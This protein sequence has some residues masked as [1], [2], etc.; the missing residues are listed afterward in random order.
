MVDGK[1]VGE[2]E[3]TRVGESEGVLVGL[4]VGN[5]DGAGEGGLLGEI[6]G[7]VPVGDIVFPTVG[8]VVLVIVGEGVESH[9]PHVPAHVY[10]C[11]SGVQYNPFLFEVISGLGL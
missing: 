9:N 8:D 1:S 6:V 7:V 4:I 10:N 3:G 5:G 11:C 2:L